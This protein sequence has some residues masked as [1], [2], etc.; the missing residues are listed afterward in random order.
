[1]S[2]K[3]QAPA[4]TINIPKGSLVLMCAAPNSGKTQFTKKHFKL[5]RDTV[6]ICSDDIFCENVKNAS[7][8][9]TYETLMEKTLVTFERMVT[10]GASSGKTV[11]VDATSH[12]YDQR[13]AMINELRPLFKNIV[14]IV[15]DLDIPDLMSHGVKPQSTIMKRF[16]MY[17]PELDNT[18]LIA[19]LIKLQF[20]DRTIYKGVDTVYRVTSQTLNICRVVYV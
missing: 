15:I 6:L 5:N 11:V 16:D 1:M 19:M 10:E 12:F 17:A 13:I 8:F 9:D 2:K 3:I 7:S 20:N 18:V 14:L 4:L